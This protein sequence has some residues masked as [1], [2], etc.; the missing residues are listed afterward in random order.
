MRFTKRPFP[1]IRIVWVVVQALLSV[2]CAMLRLEWR[3]DPQTQA[4]YRQHRQLME[5]IVPDGVDE[6]GRREWEYFLRLPSDLKE[7]YRQLF[8][9]MRP[10]KARAAYEDRL[11]IVS[12][13]YR[14][15]ALPGWLSD[16]G[17]VFLVC[18]PP[19]EVQGLQEEVENPD[20]GSIEGWT[21]QRWTY[22]RGA[23]L[24]EVDFVW[25][26]GRW[27]LDFHS[28][29]GVQGFRELW[30]ACLTEYTVR[31]EGWN[32]WSGALRAWELAKK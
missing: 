22:Q 9:A 13:L 27:L 16:R 19:D 11:K 28:A 23:F 8:W 24:F 14:E 30:T 5:G 3:L 6:G 15:P 18:G 32:L 2:S 26:S 20:S 12:R 25:K 10:G 31:Q 7:R 21:A 4:W 1:S 17:K 29:T